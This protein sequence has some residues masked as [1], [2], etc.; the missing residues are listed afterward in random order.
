MILWNQAMKD[1]ETDAA[2]PEVGFG[3]NSDEPPFS[4]NKECLILK[5]PGSPKTRQSPSRKTLVEELEKESQ[6]KKCSDPCCEGYDQKATK[7]ACKLCKKYIH[8]EHCSDWVDA[9]VWCNT[10]LQENTSQLGLCQKCDENYFHKEN[11]YQALDGQQVICKRCFEEQQK[12]QETADTGG[13]DD[14][15]VDSEAVE[16]RSVGKGSVVED[17]DYQCCAK[18]NCTN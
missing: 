4:W 5:S 1:L 13:I 2:F 3:V 18:E 17:L 6:G 8:F 14:G 10:C 7:V 16:A 11:A 15:I 12:E 9:E